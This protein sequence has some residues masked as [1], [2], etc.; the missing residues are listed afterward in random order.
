MWDESCGAQSGAS[1]EEQDLRVSLENERQAV[2]DFLYSTIDQV[3]PISCSHQL[4]AFFLHA[5]GATQT[6]R[7]NLNVHVSSPL[8]QCIAA[9][10]DDS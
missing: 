10:A 7:A 9:A 1:K 6:L 2:L 4:Q 3:L 5:S 8:D